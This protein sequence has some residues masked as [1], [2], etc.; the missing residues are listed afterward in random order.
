MSQ[1]RHVFAGFKTGQ[2]ARHAASRLE[3][4]GIPREQISVMMS[5]D[6]RRHFATVE[7]HTR[8][9][10][11]AAAGGVLGGVLGSLIAGLTTIAA[12]AAPGIGLIAAGPIVALLA[13]A[14]AGAAAGGTLGG[15]IGLGLSEHELKHYS[16]IVA[17]EGVLVIVTTQD[18]ATSERARR[19]LDGSGAITLKSVRGETAHL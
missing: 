3:A 15:L 16:D 19:I 2:G 18:K 1:A 14:G 12:V 11:G 13:G 10:E 4:E 8:A 6:A 5:D 7:H 9:A 17:A